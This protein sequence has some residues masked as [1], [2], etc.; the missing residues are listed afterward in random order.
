MTF[1]CFRRN[2]LIK[3]GL[4]LDRQTLNLEL[5]KVNEK[6]PGILNYT[7]KDVKIFEEELNQNQQIEMQYEELIKQMK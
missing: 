2:D 5:Q 3:D 4:L 1:F 6:Y 7:D